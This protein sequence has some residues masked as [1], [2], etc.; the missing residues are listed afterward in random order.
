VKF[1]QNKLFLP[2]IV[3]PQALLAK[4]SRF[5]FRLP[6]L[7]NVSNACKMLRIPL[8]LLLSAKV[9]RPSWFSPA[10]WAPLTNTL[11][12]V[13][14]CCSSASFSIPVVL[15]RQFGVIG[16]ASLARP[17]LRIFS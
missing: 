1:A 9:N 13:K 7:E 10:P 4:G 14:V 17:S 8:K 11:A 2:A 12:Q 6:K 15:D 3:S 16:V 5:N